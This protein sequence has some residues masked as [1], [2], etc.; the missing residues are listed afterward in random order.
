MYDLAHRINAKS[1]LNALKQSYRIT[2][3]K[4]DAA[5]A[6]RLAP[7]AHAIRPG[8]FEVGGATV[9]FW[10][11]ACTCK[12]ARARKQKGITPEARPC[13]HFLALYLSGDW[14]P[15]FS[16]VPYFQSIEIEEPEILEIHCRA[17]LPACYPA[18]PKGFR[19]L[20]AVEG[21]ATLENIATG[22][23]AS[24]RVESLYRLRPVYGEI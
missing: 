16:P 3:N 24:A 5:R 23:H 19:I 8:V 21:W 4:T 12:T 14:L 13:P 17:K 7:T 18:A 20:E 10:R 1:S 22:T 11:S 9:D 15:G 6:Q 2:A